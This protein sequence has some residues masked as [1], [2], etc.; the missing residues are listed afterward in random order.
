MELAL[1]QVTENVVT[2]SHTQPPTA[3]RPVLVPRVASAPGQ[4][5]SSVSQVPML[6][7]SLLP[8]C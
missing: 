7:F 8:A 1:S 4:T 5:H 6:L 2:Y 3:P